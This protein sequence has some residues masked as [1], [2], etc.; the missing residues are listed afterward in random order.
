[1]LDDL[2][3]IWLTKGA[4]DATLLMLVLLFAAALA[5][6]SVDDENRIYFVA[7]AFS[8][9]FLAMAA[10]ALLYSAVA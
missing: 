5:R 7:T 4:S 6:L 1:M 9:I 2:L 10:F 3:F 8:C